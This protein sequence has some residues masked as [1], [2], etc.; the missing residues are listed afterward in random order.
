MIF[1]LYKRNIYLK[2]NI[3]QVFLDKLERNA[4]VLLLVVMC[5]GWLSKEKIL[6]VLTSETS[7]RIMY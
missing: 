1:E 2:I 5:V 7:E 4:V 6:I 3:T